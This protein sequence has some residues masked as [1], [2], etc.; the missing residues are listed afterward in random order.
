MAQTIKNPPAMQETWV[1]SP[2]GEDPLEKGV[3]TQYNMT[4]TSRIML[5]PSAILPKHF[6]NLTKNQFPSGKFSSIEQL[7]FQ[8]RE[9]SCFMS[10]QKIILV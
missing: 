4:D 6:W 8:P 9:V 7:R 10:S 3:A 1:Q 5:P 2:G